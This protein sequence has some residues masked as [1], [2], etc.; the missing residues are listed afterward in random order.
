M[1]DEYLRH[2][3]HVQPAS[4]A[5]AG[6]RTFTLARGERGKNVRLAGRTGAP[7]VEVRGPDGETV[8]TAHGDYAT[9]RT[10]QVLRQD[11]G[12][13][14]WIGVAG[15]RSGTYTITELPG[16]APVAGLAATRPGEGDVKVSV[17][18]S[19]RRRQRARAHA[20]PAVRRAR[21]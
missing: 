14:T 21:A 19:G 3:V 17:T 4:A 20:W 10:M 16:S 18:G 7:S 12:K 5:Q 9:S 1:R 13:V 15:G 11:A 6:T 2:G 8:S